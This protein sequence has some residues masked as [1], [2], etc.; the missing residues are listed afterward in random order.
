ML[1]EPQGNL[2]VSA[3]Y[4]LSR[5]AN[6]ESRKEAK[7]VK[8]SGEWW[9][10]VGVISGSPFG[11]SVLPPQCLHLASAREEK[12]VFLTLF[13]SFPSVLYFG[14]RVDE[15]NLTRYFISGD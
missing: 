5:F 13:W 1:G 9:L 11:I 4:C 2:F 7:E 8:Y 6:E 3:F 12:V 15:D 14:S 10:V